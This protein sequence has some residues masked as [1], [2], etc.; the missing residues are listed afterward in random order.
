MAEP[1]LDL[2]AR[3]KRDD[4]FWNHDVADHALWYRV[5]R[6]AQDA[7]DD[8]DAEHVKEMQAAHDVGYYAGKLEVA[9]VKAKFAD[10][11]AAAR[12]WDDGTMPELAAALA[13]L[14]DPVDAG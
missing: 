3:F 1:S 11:V 14:G 10:L 4:F 7:L 13:A 12:M 6:I 9:S 2:I 5:L 8:Q